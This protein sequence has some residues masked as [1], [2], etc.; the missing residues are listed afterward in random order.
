[1]APDLKRKEPPT[2]EAQ[3]RAGSRPKLQSDTAAAIAPE[4]QHTPVQPV[5]ASES[6]NEPKEPQDGQHKSGVN[7]GLETNEDSK[8]G[9]P[10]PE[11]AT[12]VQEGQSLTE[13]SSLRS[14][15]HSSGTPGRR[16]NVQWAPTF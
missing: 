6:Q 10:P 5:D 11:D 2:D 14:S 13:A 15:V 7:L 4:E 8:S 3:P 12:T 9:D 1:M 16:L